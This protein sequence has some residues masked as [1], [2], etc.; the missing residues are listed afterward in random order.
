VSMSLHAR[1]ST[2]RTT[3][4]ASASHLLLRRKCPCG[5]AAGPGGECEECRRKRL[6]GQ[7]D[8]PSA[9]QAFGESSL[10]HDFTQLLAPPRAAASASLNI[11]GKP[12]IGSLNAV[13]QV[14]VAGDDKPS[15]PAPAPRVPIPSPPPPSAKPEE[16]KQ[17]A[18]ACPTDVKVADVGTLEM[19]ADFAKGGWLT[20]WGGF[21][22]MQVSDPGNKTWNG[23]DIHE[24]LKNVKNT[25][26]LKGGC[27]NAGGEGGAA[28]STFKV[29]EEGDLLGLTKLPATKNVFYDMHM[30]GLKG[31]SWLHQANKP[32][33][34]IQCEQFYDC[35]G[36]RFGPTFLVTYSLTRDTIK[37]GNKS[38][39]VTQIALKKEAKP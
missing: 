25:C 37:E 3:A 28:G 11:N 5:G 18:P 15:T 8:R 35:G 22:V 12:A 21:A 26:D 10:G 39:D 4:G 2:L 33:C 19:D 17:V 32:S 24:N 34:E 7:A 14:F 13:D 27:S 1:A 23:T 36:K 31:V 38:Y 6:L 20:G 9:R 30:I 29:G 16:H